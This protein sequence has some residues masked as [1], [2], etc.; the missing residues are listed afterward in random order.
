LWHSVEFFLSD[1]SSLKCNEYFILSVRHILLIQISFFSFV[2]GTSFLLRF[3]PTRS[4]TFTASCFSSFW[5]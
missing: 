5:F 2:V 3:G 1:L 4:I